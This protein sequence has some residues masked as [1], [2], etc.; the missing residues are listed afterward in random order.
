MLYRHLVGLAVLAA[1]PLAASAAPVGM[2]PAQWEADGQVSF[3]DGVMTVKGAGATVKD[4]QFA[5]G[6]IEYDINEDGD[7]DETSGIWFRRQNATTSDYLYLR[8]FEGCAGSGECIQYAP[9]VRGKV[10]WDVYPEYQA[11]GPIHL[12]GWNHVKLVVSGQRMQMFLNGAASPSLAVGNLEG[13]APSGSV[14]LRGN[15]SYANVAVTPD[16]VEGLDSAPTVDPTAADPNYVRHWRLSP[17]SHIAIGQ[18]VQF[19][20]MPASAGWERLDAERKGFVNISRAHGTPGGEPDLIWL[21]TTI[22]SAREQVK[23]VQLGFAR[24]VWI[25]ANGKPV[26]ADKNFYYPAAARK[27]PLGRM[28]IQNGAFALPLHAGENDIVMAISNDLHSRGHYGWGFEMR[29]NDIA[30]VTLEGSKQ[31]K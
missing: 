14:Q 13:G 17:M 27:Q 31:A 18:E 9:V 11:T 6:T 23:Q 4:L 29:L 28:A 10:Q 15:A 8:P 3:A 7:E 24:Q 21:K 30:G 19:S 25:F 1:L 16:A 12:K 5:N 22:H 26:Y 20:E 2:T